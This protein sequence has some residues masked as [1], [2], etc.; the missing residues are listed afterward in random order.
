MLLSAP[1]WRPRD[2]L[3]YHLAAVGAKAPATTGRYTPGDT[4]HGSRMPRSWSNLDVGRVLGTALLLGTAALACMSQARADAALQFRIGEV[5]GEQWRLAGVAVELVRDDAG[6]LG[7]RLSAAEAELP[8]PLGRR[9]DVHAD[10]AELDLTILTI[11][12]RKLAIR[13]DGVELRGELDYQRDTGEVEADL[14]L[15][16]AAPARLSVRGALRAEGWR[17]EVN[18][19]ALSGEALAP[20]FAALEISVPP[21]AGTLDFRVFA[22]GD[23][24]PEGPE[25]LEGLVVEFAATGLGVSNDDG[26]LATEDLALEA[27]GSAWLSASGADASGAGLEFDLRGRVFGGEAYIEPVYVSLADHPLRFTARGATR[28]DALWIDRLVIDQAGTVHA[29]A[30]ISLRNGDTAGWLIEEARVRIPHAELPGAYSVLLQP[31]LAG[32]PLD[33]LATAGTLRGELS[34][35]DGELEWLW[36]ELSEVDIDDAEA[37]LAIYD[38]SGELWWAPPGMTARPPGGLGIAPAGWRVQ[39]L[40]WSGGFVYGVPFG[41]ARLRLGPE[42]GRWVLGAPISIPVLDGALEIHALEAG[43]LFSGATDVT[44]DAEL[45]PISMR[46]LSRALDWPPLSGRL[47]GALPGLR[48]AAGLL[49]LGG[50]LR[51]EVFDGEIVVEGLTVAR[52]LG[53]LA[54]LQ[55][56][57]SLRGLELRQVT[58]ALS[59]GL[60]TGRLDGHVHSLE[61]IDWQPV[62]FDARLYTPAGDRSRRRISQ[63]AVDNIAS[64]GGGGAGVL[65]TGFLRFFEEF[66]YEAFALGCRLER[67][68]C[69]MSGL[70]ARDGGYVILRGSGLPRIDV[71]GFADRV[72]WSTLLGQLESIMES[73]G[74]EVR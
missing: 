20:L 33:A 59:F 31:F 3:R 14:S 24:G 45:A 47:A 68:V 67:D 22:R 34:L 10:C 9:T 53:P 38:L 8:S 13:V 1:C 65:S 63:R 46:E 21:L 55:A 15:V 4:S 60:M 74:P 19:A 11:T 30:S 71:L 42:E 35:A 23:A 16:L 2:G 54:R 70:E 5:A 73:E 69:A 56:E 26:T 39:D 25:G 36:L 27:S 44:L 52:P 17:M 40:R 58:E 48:Y 43:D 57:V 49:E 7:A 28:K 72:S 6:R 37:R 62:A 50:A 32:T 64:I 41:A 12:C 29:D 61:M 18:A 66:A 51:A